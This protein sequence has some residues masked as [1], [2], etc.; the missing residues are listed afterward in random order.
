MS[1]NVKRAAAD[2]A[3]PAEG[4]FRQRLNRVAEC[5]IKVL[6]INLRAQ[7]FSQN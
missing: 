6:T 2:V 5:H 1:R 7:T 3:G 4:W